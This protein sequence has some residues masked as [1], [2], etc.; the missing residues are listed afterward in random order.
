M[1]QG[2]IT[3]STQKAT[4]GL[5]GVIMIDVH[6]RT[7]TTHF[8]GKANGAPAILDREDRVVLFQ[9]QPVLI[10]Q[11]NTPITPTRTLWIPHLPGF[12]LSVHFGPIL[13]TPFLFVGP[14]ALGMILS[15]LTV[16][17]V[18]SFPIG[19]TFG[20]SFD[21]LNVTTFQPGSTRLRLPL[22][23]ILGCPGSGIGSPFFGFFFVSHGEILEPDSPDPRPPIPGPCRQVVRAPCSRRPRYLYRQRK[24][25]RAVLPYRSVQSFGSVPA[26]PAMPRLARSSQAPPPV[27]GSTLALSNIESDQAFFH[28]PLTGAQLIRFRMS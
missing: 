23:W 28:S 9:R 12:L 4:D 17:G 24:S 19:L 8:I 10:P 5:G 7:F 20:F 1:S 14:S 27:L 26:A 6:V 13:R 11:L 21:V 25:K 22:L 16:V 2:W 15:P 3:A 18:Y